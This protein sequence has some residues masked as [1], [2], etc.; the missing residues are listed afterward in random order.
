MTCREFAD[1][2]QGYID[3]EIDAEARARFEHHLG[4]CPECVHYLRLYGQTPIA[5][6]LALSEELPA[7]VPEELIQ[8]IV[9]AKA[10]VP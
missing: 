4:E 10:R 9:L 6:R 2:M 1:F 7:D 5:S 3:N 8:A